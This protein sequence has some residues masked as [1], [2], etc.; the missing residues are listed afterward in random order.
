MARLVACAT[1]AEINSALSI[2][3][4]ERYLPRNEPPLGYRFGAQAKHGLHRNLGRSTGKFAR[5]ERTQI[6]ESRHLIRW[7]RGD[8]TIL[9]GPRQSSGSGDPSVGGVLH[10]LQVRAALE[11]VAARLAAEG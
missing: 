11:I 5:H 1:Y 7:R 10:L 2:G 4:T 9:V 3:N 8:G 6:V